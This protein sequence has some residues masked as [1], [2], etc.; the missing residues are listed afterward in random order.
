MAFERV[1]VD[2]G[3][4]VALLA[5]DD[6]E[7][8]RCAATSRA[9]AK[10]FLTTWPVLTEVAWMLRDQ[11]NAI[12]KILG[13][14]EQNLVACIELDAD[15]MSLISSLSRK[16]ADMRPQ[17]AD[18]SLISIADREQVS[19]VFTLDLRDFSIFRDQ[20]GRPFQLLPS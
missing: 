4:L 18:L 12:S 14:V 10:P 20:R 5:E 6:A 16:Y 7:H 13:L 3:P 9:L 2:T 8:D 17:L 11:T 15:A 1:V 19:T